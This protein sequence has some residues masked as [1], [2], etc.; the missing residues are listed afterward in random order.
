M[1]LTSSPNPR[2]KGHVSFGGSNETRWIGPFR[3]SPVDPEMDCRHR[4]PPK[5]MD[6]SGLVRPISKL[7]P[8]F[9][10]SFHVNG[11]I[12]GTG[13]MDLAFHRLVPTRN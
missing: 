1:F 3:G 7:G 6:C 8:P 10:W 2:T 9:C 5:E 13:A 12:A 4:T 11:G